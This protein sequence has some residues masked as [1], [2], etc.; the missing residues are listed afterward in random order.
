MT[1]SEPT[2]TASTSSVVKRNDYA[3]SVCE[4]CAD[5]IH[6]VSADF[7][8]RHICISCLKIIGSSI[9]INQ[10]DLEVCI[11]CEGVFDRD[12]DSERQME[13]RI[14]SE[15]QIVCGDCF[16]IFSKDSPHIRLSFRIDEKNVDPEEPKRQKLDLSSPERLKDD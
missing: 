8:S 15:R 13:K 7:G 4:G 14:T 2:K 5:E 3:C 12:K 10:D 9:K 16:D 1:S 6:L 11:G